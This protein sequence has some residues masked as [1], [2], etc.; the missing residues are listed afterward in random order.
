MESLSLWQVNIL[1]GW[2]TLFLTDQALGRPLA[3]FKHNEREI[4]VPLAGRHNVRLARIDLTAQILRRPFAGFGHWKRGMPGP[5]VGRY[6]V[7]LARISLTAQILQQPLAG[8][9]NRGMTVPAPAGRHVKLVRIA[10]DDSAICAAS[11][12]TQAL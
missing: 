11:C 8:H 5:A 4:P 3:I 10:L 1:Q 6:Y 2:H 12:R 7:R 9:C